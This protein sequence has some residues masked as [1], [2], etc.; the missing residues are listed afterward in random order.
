MC[1]STL[2]RKKAMTHARTKI[3]SLVA[4]FSLIVV[5]AQAASGAEIHPCETIS[6]SVLVSSSY[7]FQFGPGNASYRLSFEVKATCQ[8]PGATFSH[9]KGTA[10][11]VR[12]YRD[13]KLANVR[14]L[15][16]V[17]SCDVRGTIE[18]PGEN[19]TVLVL[20][21][22]NQVGAVNITYTITTDHYAVMGG[23]G[24]QLQ[25]ILSLLYSAAILL[26]IAVFIVWLSYAV[27]RYRTIERGEKSG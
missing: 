23:W 24:M 16:N 6:G 18:T 17:T 13:G 1:V 27:D 2:T 8:T 3:C 12:D 11:A 9:V 5:L 10:Q 25:S 21:D 7:E 26:G 15:L 20:N 14:G 22:G 19:W 4:A